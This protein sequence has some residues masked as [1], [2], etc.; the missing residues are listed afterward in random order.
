MKEKSC[1]LYEALEY[2]KNLRSNIRPNP[3]FLK[4]LEI[5]QG[6]LNARYVFSNFFNLIINFLILIL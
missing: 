4:Q 6:M 2:V 5:Y 1:D 3:E